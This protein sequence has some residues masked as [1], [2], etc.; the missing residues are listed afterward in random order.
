MRS[1]ALVS[2]V[3]VAAVVT[4]SIAFAA[5]KKPAD[6]SCPISGQPAKADKSA[7]LDGG[8]VYFCCGNCQAAFKKAP[9]EHAAKAH[10]QMV[11][12]GELVQTGCPFN[13]RDVNP[14]TV[15]TIGDAEVGFCC[16]NCKGKAEKAEGDDQIA[17]VF[18]DISKGF[19]TP[20]ELEKAK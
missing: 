5:A 14:S 18:G 9:E 4:A 7:E 20:A 10:L 8:K 16:N 1:R 19:K 12:T 15:I 13:G 3:A 6:C 2:F 17:L 11:A